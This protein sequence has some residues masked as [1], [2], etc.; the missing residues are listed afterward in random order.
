MSSSTLLISSITVPG[1]ASYRRSAKVTGASRPVRDNVSRVRVAVE[2]S[3]ASMG[4][5]L[6]RNHSPANLAS[7][8]PRGAS[9][10]SW[11]T[12]PAG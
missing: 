9:G 7:R 12:T 10:R 11:S 1:T 2:H 6:D 3:T 8:M 5:T 4:G